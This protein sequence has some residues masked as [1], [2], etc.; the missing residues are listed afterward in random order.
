[1][2]SQYHRQSGVK[3]VHFPNSKKIWKFPNEFHSSFIKIQ[4]IEISQI[5]IQIL[6][7]IMKSYIKESCYLFNSLQVHNLFGIFRAREGIF[8][9]ISFSNQF[10]FGLKFESNS[11]PVLQSNP[12][13]TLSRVMRC[14]AC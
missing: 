2:W 6:C 9:I 5:L 1:M 3:K 7:R 4:G 8:W 13:T 10:E 14:R 12:P 11:N